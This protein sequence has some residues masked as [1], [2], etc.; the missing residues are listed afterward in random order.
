VAMAHAEPAAAADDTP[1]FGERPE[2]AIL[3]GL[4]CE[5][6]LRQPVSRR[7]RMEACSA[8][9][10]RDLRCA[11]AQEA[12][13]P[14]EREGT[15]VELEHAELVLAELRRHR[16]HTPFF[17]VVARAPRSPWRPPPKGAAPFVS[18][19]DGRTPYRIGER[20]SSQDFGGGGCFVHATLEE[21]ERSGE[22]FPRASLAFAAPR[23]V[24]VVRGEGRWR[25]CHGKVLFDAIVPLGEVSCCPEGALRSSWRH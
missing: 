7:L 2:E 16:Q 8:R 6:C 4:A 19:F 1:E 15:E 11:L 9:A 12:M 22:A 20:C 5:V 23:A 10:A 24:L 3:E 21:A 13:S 18:V 25:L 17:K 14:E